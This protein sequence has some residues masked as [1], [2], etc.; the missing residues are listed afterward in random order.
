M[1]RLFDIFMM[2]LWFSQL[3]TNIPNRYLLIFYNPPMKYTVGK[4]TRYS[5]KTSKIVAVKLFN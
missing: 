5:N 4:D 1:N 2:G 3:K